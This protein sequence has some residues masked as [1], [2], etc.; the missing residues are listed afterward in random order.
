MIIKWH[1][2]RGFCQK[3]AIKLLYCFYVKIGMISLYQTVQIPAPLKCQNNLQTIIGQN[4]RNEYFRSL[5]VT[6]KWK[7]KKRFR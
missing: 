6:V 4:T 3:V 5:E 2:K 1:Q 7:F